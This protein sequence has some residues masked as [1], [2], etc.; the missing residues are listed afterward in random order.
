M[1]HNVVLSRRKF[2]A[3]SA[4]TVAAAT[5]V[6]V[7]ALA[8]KASATSSTL[9]ID[10]VNNTGN[11]TVYAYVTGLAIDNGNAWFLLQADGHTPYY[12][13]SP[14]STGSPLQANCAIRMGASGGS[15]TRITIP[16]IAGGRIWFS[17][18]TPLTC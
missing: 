9:N 6:A 5:P 18:G 12:P 3:A 10:L 17:I 4:A 11:N 8:S 15:P 16:H 14:S 2:V 1:E 7:A 13:S